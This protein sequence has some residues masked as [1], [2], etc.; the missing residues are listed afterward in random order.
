MKNT[1][2]NTKKS[3]EKR[4]SF[5]DKEPNPK[6]ET[7]CQLYHYQASRAR[8]AR[9]TPIALQIIMLNPIFSS[10]THAADFDAG[11]TVYPGSPNIEILKTTSTTFRYL[12]LQFH[13]LITS[14]SR[15]FLH[16]L[17]HLPLIFACLNY[18]IPIFFV[19]MNSG[20]MNC[21]ERSASTP[22]SLASVTARA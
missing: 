8:K 10:T 19:G 22:L 16:H 12:Q 15:K 5:F 9:R 2:A 4:F 6:N 14:F 1:N 13:L 3:T 21:I 11:F 18:F 7:A 17:L 20:N